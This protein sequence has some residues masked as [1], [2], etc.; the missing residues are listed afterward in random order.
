MTRPTSTIAIRRAT[1]TTKYCVITSRP[2]D[3]QGPTV[4]TTSARQRHPAAAEAGLINSRCRTRQLRV[5]ADIVIIIISITS[6]RT[7]VSIIGDANV[8]RP[9]ACC[10]ITGS[11]R[12]RDWIR[13]LM[14]YRNNLRSYC[15]SINR[16][17][18]RRMN[19]AERRRAFFRQT[20]NRMRTKS[21][22]RIARGVAPRCGKNSVLLRC[23]SK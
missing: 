6:L 22:S 7:I 2:S 12:C 23:C 19:L 5:T 1:P 16:V 13:A 11:C 9:L 14:T 21:R 4:S 3:Y 15:L 10:L 20:R 17:A 18:E 8:R